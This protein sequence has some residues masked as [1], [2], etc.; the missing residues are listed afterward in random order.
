MYAKSDKLTKTWSL[1]Q[2]NSTAIDQEARDSI[3]KGSTITSSTI[4]IPE[5][6]WETVQWA[7]PSSE[8]HSLM[9]KCRAPWFIGPWDGKGQIIPKPE[10]GIILKRGEYTTGQRTRRA[11]ELCLV[12]SNCSG[13][14]YQ[15]P[16][17]F[18][19]RC[20]LCCILLYNF[21]WI[22]LHFI[23]PTKLLPPQSQK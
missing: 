16:L 3:A 23:F 1:F 20:H 19:L 2:T 11:N 7:W 6:L 12:I 18:I 14:A 15:R 9:V 5:S 10:L 4:S 8:G 22:Y 21:W 13:S 17:L